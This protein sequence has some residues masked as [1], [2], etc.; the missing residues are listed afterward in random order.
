[1]KVCSAP[2]KHRAFRLTLTMLALLKSR[3]TLRWVH[4][5]L[6][7]L[8]VPTSKMFYANGGGPMLHCTCGLCSPLATP[9]VSAS[10]INTGLDAIANTTNQPCWL[11]PTRLRWAP[12]T[13]A[14]VYDHA[15]LQCATLRSFS[16]LWM[17][18]SS[19]STDAS[20]FRQVRWG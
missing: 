15:L 3:E 7:I 4:L 13:W 5:R 2:P 9:S 11:C 12:L 1:M 10:D 14:P 18:T 16:S 6:L 20:D 19:V 17:R 8:N